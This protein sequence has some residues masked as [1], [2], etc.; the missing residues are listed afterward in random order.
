LS[1]SASPPFCFWGKWPDLVW[2][3]SLRSGSLWPRTLA[4][5]TMPYEVKVSTV[6]IRWQRVS[7]AEKQ[8]L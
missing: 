8:K 2:W 1:H 3:D 7:S 6:E 4:T 5:L